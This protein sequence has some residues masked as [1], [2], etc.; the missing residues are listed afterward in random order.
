MSI[1]LFSLRAFQSALGTSLN[2]C[3]VRLRM[4]LAMTKICCFL[5]VCMAAFSSR[6][7]GDECFVYTLPPEITSEYEGILKSGL[8]EKSGMYYAQYLNGSLLLLEY[9][10]CGL[11]INAY[12]LTDNL[13]SKEELVTWLSMIIP[14]RASFEMVSR[15]LKSMPSL[16]RD[17]EVILNG[18]GDEHMLTIGDS[19]VAIATYEIRY[20]WIPMEH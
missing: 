3:M 2:Y 8:N 5:L 15:Q 10:V 20:K 9:G 18:Y 12:Y 4:T 16:E 7:Y 6:S 13:L 11:S 14:S 19:K 1:G 17:A